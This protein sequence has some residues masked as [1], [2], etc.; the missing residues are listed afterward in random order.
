VPFQEIADRDHF[1]VS[2]WVLLLLAAIV[3]A[4]E[5]LAVTHDHRTERVIAERRLFD[6]HAHEVGVRFGRR[7][8]DAARSYPRCDRQRESA[9]GSCDQVAPVYSSDGSHRFPLHVVPL[10]FASLA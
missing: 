2:R 10:I 5:H 3:A 9:D 1:A 7:L 6:G 8:F 4:S